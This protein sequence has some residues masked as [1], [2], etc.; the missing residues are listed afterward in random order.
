MLLDYHLPNKCL[1]IFSELCNVDYQSNIVVTRQKEGRR[2]RG[3]EHVLVYI[4]DF[5]TKVYEDFLFFICRVEVTIRLV[6]EGDELMEYKN[7]IDVKES[8]TILLKWKKQYIMDKYEWDQITL[9]IVADPIDVDELTLGPIYDFSQL[10][11]FWWV[12]TR[13]SVWF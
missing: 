9:L 7:K 1:I 12:N 11:R 2:E 5:F 3:R 6:R 10:S 8:L 13:P 4:Y